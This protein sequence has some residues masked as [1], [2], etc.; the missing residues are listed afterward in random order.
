MASF[1]LLIS[2]S[3]RTEVGFETVLRELIDSFK[4]QVA[5]LQ[6]YRELEWMKP[7]YI[8]KLQ[9]VQVLVQNMEQ[10]INMVMELNMEVE[11]VVIYLIQLFLL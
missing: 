4:D 11:F 2:T 3:R 9:L 7:E 5:F 1:T 10:R 8:I 6:I